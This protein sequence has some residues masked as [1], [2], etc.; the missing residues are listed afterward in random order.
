[1]SKQMD[2][3]IYVDII[4]GEKLSLIEVPYMDITYWS[5]CSSSVGG[6]FES[7]CKVLN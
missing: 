5:V 4:T 3:N 6:E 1:M 2:I 7:L